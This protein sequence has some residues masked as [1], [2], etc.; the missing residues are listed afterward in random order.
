M[1]AAPAR[2]QSTG[3]YSSAYLPAAE[4]SSNRLD[5]CTPVADATSLPYARNTTCGTDLI[6]SVSDGDP[7][8]PIPQDP[9]GFFA[10]YS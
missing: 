9:S 8:A 2:S 7:H 4:T 3:C 6:Q 1:S 10:K 5:P